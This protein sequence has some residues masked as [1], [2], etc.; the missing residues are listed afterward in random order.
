[1][2]I[3]IILFMINHFKK[4]EIF[5]KQTTYAEFKLIISFQH[6]IFYFKFLLFVRNSN[7]FTRN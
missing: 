4:Y 2:F 3:I 7:D 5:N 1:M 6:I